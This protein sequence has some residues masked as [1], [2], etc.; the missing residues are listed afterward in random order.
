MLLSYCT[1]K[2]Y[3]TT[4]GSA[5]L[6]QNFVTIEYIQSYIP[7]HF[8]K[9]VL[10]SLITN[11]ELQYPLKA[12]PC[13]YIVTSQLYIPLA[14][15]IMTRPIVARCESRLLLFS[16]SRGCAPG[17]NGNINNRWPHRFNSNNYNNHLCL[18]ALLHIWRQVV[19]SGL[20]CNPGQGL[21]LYSVNAH[22]SITHI[23]NHV[24]FYCRLDR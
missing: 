17:R 6:G 11:K 21:L 1:Y 2:C 10:R 16:S 20:V 23:F 7:L 24:S 9:L 15:L 5:C 3:M 19:W 4:V 8:F 18:G 13:I 12:A 22:L 14:A